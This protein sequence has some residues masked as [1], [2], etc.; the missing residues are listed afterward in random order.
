[1][2]LNRTLASAKDKSAALLMVQRLTEDYPQL[3][4]ARYALARAAANAD[5]RD[6]ALKEIRRA[7]ELKPDW[8]YKQAIDTSLVEK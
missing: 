5:Q 7:Q 8:N 4:E 2:Q 1:M 6:F 3:A